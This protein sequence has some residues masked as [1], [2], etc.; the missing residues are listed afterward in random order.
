MKALYVRR[1]AFDVDLDA[2]IH[3]I[4]RLDHFLDDI[5]AQK[6]THTRI[7]RYKWGDPSENPLLNRPFI[8]AQT[9]A[10]G[11]LNGVVENMFAS[12]WSTVPLD[13]AGY[14][15]SFSYG[16]PSVRIQSTAGKLL[17]AVMSESN[18]HYSV[19]HSIGKVHYF[20]EAD[21]DAYFSDPDYSK[22]LDG[23]GY[24]IH[25]SLMRLGLD[26]KPE[27]EVRLIY[28]F[29]SNEDWV[30][31]NVRLINQHHAQ[32]PFGWADT[33]ESIVI[34]PFVRDGGQKAAEAELRKQGIVCPI[35]SSATRAYSG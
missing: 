1:N 29:M 27:Q 3:R 14:W 26:M 9:G 32:V 23:L 5:R 19:Q 15:A 12:C 11:T 2:P 10:S 21:L 35:S 6:F 4:V 31:R 30:R 18:P 16:L 25:L 33:I 22:H 8:D 7:N 17:S 24:G 28:D 34:G 20:S 13:E